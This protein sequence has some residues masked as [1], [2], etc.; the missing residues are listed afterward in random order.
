MN[1]NCQ[2]LSSILDLPVKTHTTPLHHTSSG[3]C[4]ALISCNLRLSPDGLILVV[5][6]AAAAMGVRDLVNTHL[7]CWGP[8]Q[9]K[10]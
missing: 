7:W 4:T 5:V 6:V 8:R 3:S 2:L 1:I 9:N 10:L